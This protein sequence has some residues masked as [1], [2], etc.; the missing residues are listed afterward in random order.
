MLNADY[1]EYLTTFYS[2]H[3]GLENKPYD[4]QIRVRNESLFGTV[5]FYSSNLRKLGVEA[6]DIYLNNEFM[7][8]AWA[9]EHLRGVQKTS[10]GRQRCR[11]IFQRAVTIAAKTP[12]RRL[13][14]LIPA[15]TGSASQDNW[16]YD[17]L[18]AQIREAKPDIVLK[19]MKVVAF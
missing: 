2:H 9:R 13:R 10:R 7:Q 12:L 4:E 1:P 15:R 18:A 6:Y 3:P 19:K 17:I 8:K 14:S 11:K 16:Y 5:D